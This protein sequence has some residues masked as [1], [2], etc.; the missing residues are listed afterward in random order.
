MAGPLQNTESLQTQKVHL[1]QADL[2]D[3]RPFELGHNVIGTRRFIQGHEISQ[4]LIGNNNAGS[5]DRRVT[6]KTFELFAYVYDLSS[7]LALIVSLFQLGL[8]LQRL[9]KRHIKRERHKFRQSV[10]FTQM[11]A[12]HPADVTDNCAG[13]H[14]SERDDLRDV[15]VLLTDIFDN[16][17]P[18]S[19]TDINVNIGHLVTVRIHESLEEQIVVNR[20]DIA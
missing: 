4:R 8:G 20:V 18:V 9:I 15:P 17:R 13:L 12:E 7:L 3:Y 5:V 6:R 11:H 2:L 19:L 1:Q 14:R 10:G 16:F